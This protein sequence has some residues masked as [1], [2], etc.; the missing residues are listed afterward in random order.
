[1]NIID[2]F[3][4][5]GKK[6]YVTGGARG[7]GKSAAI[8]L[9]QAG[10]DVAIVDLDMEAAEKTAE[11]IASYGIKAIA[12]KADISVPGDVDAM[13]KKILDTYGTIDVAFNNAG[14]CIN[15]NAME[16]S[17]EE[18]RKVIDINLTG[19]FLTTKAAGEV[20][21]RNKKGSIINTAS[22]AGHVIPEPQ[23]HCAYSASKAGVIQLSKALAM[24]WAVYNV[25]VNCLSPGYTATELTKQVASPYW[26]ERTPLKR[27]GDPED[28][29]GAIIYLASDASL[30]TTGID[31]VVDGGYCC[32]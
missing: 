24:E 11:E 6:A 32:W 7:I 26:S 18:W 1:M 19:M 31:I 2:R 3:K 25:R 8:G 27:L 28:M 21:I 29:Q 5:D 16:M 22:M 12:I 15:K 13:M 10:A 14:I 30:Y 9:A 17:L 4:L 20:M 23:C